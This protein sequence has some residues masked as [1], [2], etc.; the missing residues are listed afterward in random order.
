MRI[1]RVLYVS[2]FLLCAAAFVA[3]ARAATDG[4]LPL[5]RFAS[6]A[7]DEVNIR[8]GPG[9]RYPIEWVIRREGLPVEIIREFDTWREIRDH[10]GDSGWVHQSLLSG[11]R[12]VLIDGHIRTMY[13]KPSEATRPVAR[14]EPGVTVDLDRCDK[15]WCYL[16][17]AGYEGWVRRDGLWGVYPGEEID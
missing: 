6:L 11:R 7:A 1:D 3:P 10:A 15:E 9:L 13:R 17:V 16:S 14:L 4:E 2:V 5:P 8:K 12:T